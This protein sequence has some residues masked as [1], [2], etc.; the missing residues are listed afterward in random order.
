M[1]P[2]VTKCNVLNRAQF[3]KCFISFDLATEWKC[4][5]KIASIKNYNILRH[6]CNNLKRKLYCEIDVKN[7]CID[8]PIF[9][10]KN[11]VILVIIQELC[12]FAEAYRLTGFYFTTS[13]PH[14]SLEAS[15]CPGTLHRMKCW[16][17]RSP[18]QAFISW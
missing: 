11:P 4:V 17:S 18:S 14:V 3:L 12:S 6:E 16:C 7:H 1:Q 15:P 13:P 9:H 10:F 5:R 2:G 8:T